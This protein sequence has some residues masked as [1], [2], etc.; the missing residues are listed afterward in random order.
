MQ[1]W[2]EQ[3]FEIAPGRISSKL[4]RRE[5]LNDDIFFLQNWGEEVPEIALGVFIAK[6]GRA[7][8]LNCDRRFFFLSF[9]QKRGV[10]IF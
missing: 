9:L 5:I 10:Q 6:Q 1:N 3:I 4:G 2:R 8:I 7:Y